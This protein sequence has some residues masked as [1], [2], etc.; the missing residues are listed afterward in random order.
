[1][2]YISCDILKMSKIIHNISPNS[3]WES[4]FLLEV[5]QMMYFDDSELVGCQM[6]D[7]HIVVDNVKYIVV[8][9]DA[10]GIWVI[11]ADE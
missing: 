9:G 3:L 7:N 2:I 8:K 6:V 1:M 5:T 4:F 11:E 10:K